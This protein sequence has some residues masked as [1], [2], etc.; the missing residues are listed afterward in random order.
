[1]KMIQVKADL[2][3]Q[4]NY[5]TAVLKRFPPHDPYFTKNGQINWVT[6]FSNTFGP[7]ES[8][9]EKNGWLP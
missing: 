6:N 8:D 7:T 1:M 5:F 2:N 4:K 9:S 3:F